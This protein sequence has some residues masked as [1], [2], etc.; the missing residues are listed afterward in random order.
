VKT[1]IVF[2][3]SSHYR[4]PSLSRYP[5]RCT[6]AALAAPRRLLLPEVATSC[7]TLLQL[8]PRATSAGGRA[9]TWGGRSQHRRSGVRTQCHPVKHLQGP[10]PAPP[11]RHA[12]A[13]RARRQIDMPT[14]P[15]PDASITRLMRPDA[16]SSDVSTPSIFFIQVVTINFRFF[17]YVHTKIKVEMFCIRWRINEKERKVE[18]KW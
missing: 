11:D 4:N 8:Q 9:A 6:P 15:G 2:F 13:A 10:M 14:P 16:S 5:V 3:A 12:H 17:D 1:R 7:S 18:V